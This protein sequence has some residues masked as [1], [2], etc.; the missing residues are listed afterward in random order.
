MKKSLFAYCWIALA[1]IQT[2]EDSEKFKPYLSNALRVPSE[3]I[4]AGN[5]VNL[6]AAPA[7][8]LSGID[9]VIGLVCGTGTGLRTIKVEHKAELPPSP[10]VEA[11][12]AVD[13]VNGEVS[14]PSTP[15]VRNLPIEDAGQTR[16]WGYMIDDEGSAY[17]IGRLAMRYLLTQQDR[18]NSPLIYSKE[19]PVRGPLYRDLME[20]FGIKV[21]AELIRIVALMEPD[22]VEGLSI[23]EA[24]AKRNAYMAG[25]ARVVFKWA[26]PE[27][28]GVTIT[29]QEEKEAH[30]AAVSIARNAV[31]PVA[32][33]VTLGLGDRTI[34]RPDRTALDLGGGLMNSKGYV[35]LLLDAL[36]QNGVVF[37]NVLVVDDAAG[38]GAKALAAVIFGSQ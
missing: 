17:W 18:E 21:P 20:Y 23:G 7:L 34:V 10:P 1:G 25:A 30:E 35:Q 3:R 38:E 4:F 12:D 5:D 11:R 2:E 31:R 24:S 14:R 26:F 13:P 33:L 22:F 9:H 37:R 28:G 29:T 15:K 32:E 27:E 16:G 8:L 19:A 6:L 36:A